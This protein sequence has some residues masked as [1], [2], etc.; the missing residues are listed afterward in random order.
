MALLL[1]LLLAPPGV[2]EVALEL[3]AEAGPLL[4]VFVVVADDDGAEPTLS[5]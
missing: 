5:C 1:I 3:L 4:V 2:F